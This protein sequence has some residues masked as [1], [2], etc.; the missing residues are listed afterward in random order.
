MI[1]VVTI[2]A[3][4]GGTLARQ[5]KSLEEAKKKLAAVL[6]SADRVISNNTL[7]NDR[8]VQFIAVVDIPEKGKPAI[9]TKERK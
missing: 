1:D 4:K 5:E 2:K 9:S 8:E 3:D 7:E 6:K